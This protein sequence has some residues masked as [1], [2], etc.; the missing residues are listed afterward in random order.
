VTRM[1]RALGAVIVFAALYAVD[2]RAEQPPSTS[3]TAIAAEEERRVA[4]EEAR[5]LERLKREYERIAAE[6]AAEERSKEVARTER[7]FFGAFMQMVLVLGAICMLAY[8]VLGKMLPKL[9][10]IEPPVALAQGRRVMQVIDRLPLDQRRSILLLRIG[11]AHYLVG[12]A[13][14]GISLLS[15][16][17]SDDVDEALATAQPI[18]TPP[19]T[20]L[21]SVFA[22]RSSGPSRGH[23]EN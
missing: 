4:E 14:Q 5:R 22:R 6:P 13:D 12:R 10:R 11:T 1:K 7:S 23:K 19:L 3:T 2:A 8:L 18:A 17:D 21:A 16:L 20:R 15:R 9:M